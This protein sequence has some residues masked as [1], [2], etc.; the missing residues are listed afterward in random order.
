MIMGTVDQ[1][2]YN[3]VSR[4]VKLVKN[5]RMQLR[6]ISAGAGLSALKYKS[7]PS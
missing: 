4:V 2:K 7:E 3:Y 6:L 5:Q 1:V